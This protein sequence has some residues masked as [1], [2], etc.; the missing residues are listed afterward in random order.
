MEESISTII[1]EQS[2][3]S[4]KRALF[5]STVPITITSFLIPLAEM[6]KTQGYE[7]DC[8][9]AKASTYPG[10]DLFKNRF[11]ISW[12][13][14]F[15]DS[16][17]SYFKS[18]KEIRNIATKGNYSVIHVHTPIAAFITRLALRK[19]GRFGGPAPSIIYT[20]HGFHFHQAESSRFKNTLFFLAE[21]LGLC[22]TDYLVVMN[23]E[24]EAAAQK[25]KA[26]KNCPF[27]RVCLTQKRAGTQ[28]CSRK[29]A[30]ISRIDGIG[31]D[32]ASRAELKAHNDERRLREAQGQAQSPNQDQGRGQTQS[33]D[34]SYDQAQTQSPN[35]NYDQ[36]Q[37]QKPL[38]LVMIAELNH[39]KSQLKL[40]NE[41]SMLKS[42]GIPFK[43]SFIGSGE[44]KTAIESKTLHLGLQDDV[45]LHG[46][47]SQNEIIEIL[48][49]ADLGLLVSRREGLPRSL[50][51]MIASGVP[52]I[53]TNTRGIADE[54]RE[55]HALVSNIGFGELTALIRKL[56][57]ER[58]VL[59]ALS[60]TQ[61]DYAIA[62]FDEPIILDAYKKLYTQ[63]QADSDRRAKGA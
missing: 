62:H 9:A 16:A 35:Q 56:S 13:R 58:E 26:K 1:P 40:L 6:L 55:P 19:M 44:L 60:Q 39:N 49:T 50:M 25:L 10:L 48:K 4:Q 34:Q 47:L 31:F 46:Q 32:F 11:N 14:S 22:W 51:E 3:N 59:A 30:Q 5:V 27:A 18:T 45:T 37:T 53:G 21:K 12:S 29:R 36:A 54:V 28:R 8:A 57:E 2:H 7:L 17:L 52:V 61:Y 24:D 43:M 63:A 42:E 23:D 20:V 33:Q 38:H 41:L 15:K